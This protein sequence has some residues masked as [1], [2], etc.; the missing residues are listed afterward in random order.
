MPRSRNIKPSFFMNDEL[1]D[2]EPLARLLFIGLWTIADHKGQ[3]E[4]RPARIKAQV[5]PY[6]NCDINQLMINL[7]KSRLITFYSDSANTYVKIDNFTKHQ[8]PHPNERKVKSGIPDYTDKM[9]QLVDIK[10]LAINKL[11]VSDEQVSDNADSCFPLTDSCSP[12]PDSLNKHLSASQAKTDEHAEVITKIFEYWRKVMNKDSR[13]KLTQKRKS[14]INARLKDGFTPKEICEAIKGCASSA[15][16]MG[17]N[18]AG[19]VYDDLELICRDD[20]KLRKFL[21]IANNIK[22]P[23]SHNT[24]RNID[25][26]NNVELD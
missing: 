19:T 6:D 26:L 18:D 12:D 10:G 5:L 25:A 9:R 8:N 16:H 11:A 21:S 1:G 4:Y 17:E 7:D 24:A 3:L 23:F 22:Q 20:G 14:K 15:Y 13:S 2:L